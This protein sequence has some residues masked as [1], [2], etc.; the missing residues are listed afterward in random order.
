M[1]DRK[2]V[3]RNYEDAIKVAHSIYDIILE[4]EFSYNESMVV[5]DRVEELLGDLS[6]NEHSVIKHGAPL[7]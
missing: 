7:A 5:L 4:N 1:N 3:Y 2:V 6:F